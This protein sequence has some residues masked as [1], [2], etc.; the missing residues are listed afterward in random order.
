[1]PHTKAEMDGLWKKIVE[2]H[3]HT[4]FHL[5]Y[6]EESEVTHVTFLQPRNELC[7]ALEHIV[8]AKAHEFGLGKADAELGEDYEYN[9]LDKALG[10]EFR[11]FFDVCDW[12]SI[13]L[14]EGIR[15]ELGNYSPEVIETVIPNY[16]TEIRPML[17][18]LPDQIAAIRARK[19]IKGDILA[20]VSEYNEI[21]LE[22][23]AF[24]VSL[25][26]KIP[27]L[28]EVKK[29]GERKKIWDVLLLVAAAL[30]E[31]VVIWWWEKT[32]R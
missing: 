23:K 19:D 16:Y 10:H 26:A 13:I 5:L 25:S 24:R 11:A 21:L 14:R 15:S 31:A 27:S 8:R 6:C 22:L 1:M 28:E 4:K 30:I 12:L 17:D 29:G 2:I 7:N 20:E 32:H 18:V 3:N 9:T